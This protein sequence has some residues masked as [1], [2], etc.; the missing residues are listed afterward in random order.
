MVVVAAVT[1]DTVGAGVSVVVN[2]PSPLTIPPISSYR[3][4]SICSATAAAWG[5]DRAQ[6]ALGTRRRALCP[7]WGPGGPGTRLCRP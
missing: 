2:G 3:R 5:A 4:T 6:S 7:P 1:V